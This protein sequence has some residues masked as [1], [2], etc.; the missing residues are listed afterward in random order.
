MCIQFR[1]LG[2]GRYTALADDSTK[3]ADVMVSRKGHGVI[4]PVP[5]RQLNSEERSSLDAFVVLMTPIKRPK[6]CAN[7]C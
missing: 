1:P 2:A 3:I 5:G 6:H 7:L 4:D